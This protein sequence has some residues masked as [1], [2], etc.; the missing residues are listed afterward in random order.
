MA[1]DEAARAKGKRTIL[2]DGAFA[3]LMDTFTGGVFLA[4]LGLYVG[5]GNATIGVL[6]A[7]PLFAQVAQPA[8]VEL[9]V[10]VEDRRMVTV[11]ASTL[12]RLLLFVI[13]G[14]VLVLGS[15][16]PPALLVAILALS[17]VFAVVSSAAWNWWMRD[18][19]PRGELGTYFGGRLRTTTV[20]GTVG[21]L[22]AGWLLDRFVAR[23]AAA[24]GYA[25]L[26]VLGG[27]AGIASC[28]FL[29][30]TPHEAGRPI[31][32]RGRNVVSRLAAVAWL[33]ANR[34]LVVALSL[35]AA[36]LTFALPFTAVYLLR[37]AQ[38]TFLAVTILAFVSQLAYV[39]AIRGWGFLSDRFGN[40]PVLSISLGMV[41]LSL[42]GWAATGAFGP[43]ALFAFLVVLHF[44]AG[45]AL[46]G[47]ELTSS[48]IL[49]KVAPEDDAPAFLAAMSVARS[50]AA[51]TSTVLAGL[52]WHAVGA[53]VVLVLPVGDGGWPIRGFH[54]LALTAATLGLFALLSLRLIVE[55][56]GAPVHQVAK[57][58]RR[59]V[60]SI[61]SIAG[62]RAFVHAVSY[63]VE[64]VA[65]DPTEARRVRLRAL[66]KGERGA[67]G[68][69]GLDRAAHGVAEEPA[70]RD[71]PASDVRR[72]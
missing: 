9:L 35:S 62:I 14:L 25:T 40:R 38:Y 71:E 41:V 60:A 63:V 65:P 61:S 29:L 43:T 24:E 15:S 21:L 45:F 28:G 18:L 46:G 70:D 34:R 54:L 26:Y 13:A 67:D 17:A 1:L 16:M 72:R 53:G 55:E 56:G 31:G 64:F 2:L 66:R 49:L 37:S 68:S 8:A 7:L 32:N 19:I 5:A 27:A 23:G 69:P 22:S 48:N 58:M 10:R 52:L 30:A 20:V 33:P 42:L 12:S 4:G 6:A 47:V 36:A 39:A 44:V 50:L 59:E 57:A 51:G 11:L 3:R